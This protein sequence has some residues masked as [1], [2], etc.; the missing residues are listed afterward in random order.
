MLFIWPYN[1]LRGDLSDDVL[2]E[3]PPERFESASEK[4]S[5]TAKH[6]ESVGFWLI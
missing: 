3:S 4:G 2:V 1:G 5:F 6:L